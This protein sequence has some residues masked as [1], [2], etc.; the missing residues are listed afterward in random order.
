[1]SETTVFDVDYPFPDLDPARAREL[2]RFAAL[3][4]SDRGLASSSK[5]TLELLQS[6]PSVQVASERRFLSA[7]S[8]SDD[9]A[10]GTSTPA[11]KRRSHARSHI[12]EH[13]TPALGMHQCMSV[14]PGAEDG[15]AGEISGRFAPTTFASSPL[16]NNRLSR[17]ASPRDDPDS[18]LITVDSEDGAAS[19]SAHVHWQSNTNSVDC[20]PGASQLRLGGTSSAPLALE[21]ESYL[22]AKSHFDQ[23][24]L[25]RCI[26]VLENGKITSDKARFLCLYARFLMSERKLDEHG[27]IIPKPNGTLPATSPSLIPILKEL[28][29]ASDPFFLFLKGAILRKLNRPIEAMDCLI[30]SV[31]SFAYNWAA[32][33][34]LAM[35]L[36]PG[37]A[38][39]MADLLPES[40]MV[41]FFREFLD[42]HSAQEGDVTIT[43]IDRL[44][45]SFPRSAY[46]LT[47]RAQTNV[48]RLDYIEAEQD[49]Q[50]AWS[51]DPYRIDGLADYSNALYLLNRTAELAHLAHKF[52]SFA[53]DRPEVCCL[54]GNY[55][56]QRSDHHRAIEAFRH[57]LRLDSGCVPAWILLGHEYIELKNSHAAA[58]M[59][60]RALKINP[61]EYRALYGLGQVYELNGAYTYAVNYFQKCA[62]IRPYDG[63]MWSSMGICYDHLGRSQDAISCFKRYLACRLNQGDT[64]MGLTRIIE[65]YEKE[66][67]FEAAACYHRRLVQVVDRA[68]AGTESNVVARYARSY[69]IAA[70]WEMGEI[71]AKA[72]Q[73]Q[74]SEAGGVV[75][76]DEMEQDGEQGSAAK[77]GNLALANDYLQKVIAA[78]TEMTD[79]AEILLKRLAFLR[80]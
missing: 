66:R 49:F 44:L 64:V 14:E 39:Q 43:R 2:L 29:D 56:N 32:W 73:Q 74:R 67:D 24:Q 25:E 42:R 31:Q 37:E 57:A 38:D 15:S 17:V 26:W 5:W 23:H 48:H 18:S 4:L 61:R 13:S 53:K 9:S 78:G 21:E 30:R 47:C 6:V 50:E 76:T 16:V 55:Y 63:R 11:T 51:I 36:E 1:M 27:M 46:L 80:D 54:V 12:P 65:V 33:Q 3:E 10:M 20:S 72:A 79:S 8:R 71:G 62:A 22:L 58:E 69:I 41:S 7:Q 60:R 52:S 19:G 45:E 68:L 77:V 28:V 35:T 59:Y 34:E 40:F 75:T 70:R